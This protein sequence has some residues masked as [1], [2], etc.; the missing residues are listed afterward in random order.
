MD[1][2]LLS[3]G[4]F[5]SFWGAPVSAVFAFFAPRSL[6][7]RGVLPLLALSMAVG[8]A[9]SAA[10]L[11]AGGGVLQ[12]PIRFSG[13]PTSLDRISAFFF[14]IVTFIGSLA[15]LYAIPYLARHAHYNVKNANGLL[16][17]FLFGM[18]GLLLADSP[19]LFLL[20]WETMSM[21]SFFLV[22]ADHEAASVRAA[23]FYLVMTHLGAGALLAAFAVISDGNMFLPFSALPEI[24][25]TLSPVA[26]ALALAL[27]TFGFGS[28]AGLVPAHVWLPEAHPQAPSHISA[29]MSGVMLKMAVF[30]FLKIVLLF[31]PA[32]LHPAWSVVI[33]G[34]G[35][36][37]A[38]YGV[39]Y[40]ILERDIKRVLA[41]S[42]I[43]N[44][45]L[46]F[47]MVGIFLY[48]A[49]FDIIPLRDLAFSLIFF[50]SFCHAVFKSGL[51][52]GAGVA[53]DAAGSRSLEL[54]GG[55]A[56]R[57]P[58]FS[59]GFCL[60]ALGAAALPPF[61]AFMGEAALV[62]GLVASMIAGTI[63]T[64]GILLSVLSV[65]ALVGGLAVFSM[66]KLFAIAF[67][68]EPRGAASAQ[69]APPEKL[70]SYPVIGLGAISIMIG[71]F[72]SR[73]FVLFDFSN[74][75]PAQGALGI[76]GGMNPALLAPVMLA[77]MIGLALGRR[78][79][80]SA[81]HE[82]ISHT[83]D[84]GQPITAAMEYTATA[85]SAP[86]RFF[87]RPFLRTK[88]EV[89]VV[90]LVAENPWIVR[91]TFTLDLRSIWY[92][93]GYL[94]ISKT[95]LSLST[96]VRSMQ[97]GVIQFYLALILGALT[98]TLILAL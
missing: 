26:A 94:P 45:G 3:L 31:H 18:Q 98:L 86:I 9:A 21:S 70:L 40:S 56:K 76:G 92:D 32:T 58:S 89:A 60:L 53:V 79:V 14:F 59:V 63:F 48:A 30:G 6:Q 66:V 74:S 77:I 69:A 80:S 71:M 41:Y 90:P 85:F 46:I 73:L 93:Y 22:M 83:W 17:L 67:L 61:G 39:L 10:F 81:A 68:A 97:N 72:A 19:F 37:S 8:A 4:I 2:T 16:A 52:M 23:I 15:S 29:L 20:F 57:M 91:R 62:R 65:I 87:F 75:A 7:R 82:R 28:K 11:L 84:C 34:L 38:F 42:S 33:I 47:T 1:A 43:E 12:N 49:R 25:G 96:L 44:L 78:L 35:L 51:F 24:I 50:Q 55:L 88:K 54:M 36:L 64:K 95:F 27:F 13:L 5:L